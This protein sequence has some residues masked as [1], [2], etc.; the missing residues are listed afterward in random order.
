MVSRCD[1]ANQAG[2]KG[3]NALPLRG[4]LPSEGAVFCLGAARRQKKGRL[5]A[6]S[7]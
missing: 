2:K 4:S 6:L 5:R 7:A 1:A 3:P